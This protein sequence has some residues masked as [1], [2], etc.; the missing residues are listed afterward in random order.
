VFIPEKTPFRFEVMARD[1]AGFVP[2][3]GKKNK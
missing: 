3:M 1:K 2:K